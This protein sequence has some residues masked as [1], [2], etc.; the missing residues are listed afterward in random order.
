L[1]RVEPVDESALVEFADKTRVDELFD[2][3]PGDFWILRA[4]KR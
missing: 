2:I 1:R 3:Q 4:I